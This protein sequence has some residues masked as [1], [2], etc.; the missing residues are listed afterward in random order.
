LEDLRCLIS[1]LRD[2]KG[3]RLISSDCFIG[4]FETPQHEMASSTSSG[5]ALSGEVQ[6]LEL[7]PNWDKL[8]G[9][10][11]EDV[12]VLVLCSTAFQNVTWH[13]AIVNRLRA[14]QPSDISD[15]GILSGSSHMPPGF[16]NLDYLPGSH[17]VSYLAYIVINCV[18]LAARGIK[19][20]SEFPNITEKFNKFW[21]HDVTLPTPLPHFRFSSRLAEIFERKS[22]QS[23]ALLGPL[24][25]TIKTPPKNLDIEIL[26]EG[27]LA[28][29]YH[30]FSLV[31]ERFVYLVDSKL[32]N[33]F[34]KYV[35]LKK[36]ER[37]EMITSLKES[38]DIIET[39]LVH[40]WNEV[41]W[42]WVH[43]FTKRETGEISMDRHS[44][45][46]LTC[47]ALKAKGLADHNDWQMEKIGPYLKDKEEAIRVANEILSVGKRKYTD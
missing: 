17:L 32:I 7:V 45:F 28:P 15:T 29:L 9:P 30:N 33:K 3:E 39:F 20:N 11:T 10:S 1:S 6:N 36:H 38:K 2:I 4:S 34:D 13:K 22:P 23:G 16:L 26:G 41:T 8:R 25:W 27:V 37:S 19:D 35:S 31:L 46:T 14:L 40:M 47:I 5:G 18:S 24:V 12:K 43:L 42:K 21:N 44:F